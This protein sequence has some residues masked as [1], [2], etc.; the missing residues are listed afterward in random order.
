MN[1]PSRTGSVI[2]DAKVT[3]QISNV[4]PGFVKVGQDSTGKADVSFKLAS[5]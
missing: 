2:L 5:K 1:P 4:S 3:C